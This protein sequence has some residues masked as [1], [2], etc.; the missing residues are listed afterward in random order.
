MTTPTSQLGTAIEDAV[1]VGKEAADE[2]SACLGVAFAEVTQG[3]EELRRF[4]RQRA[5][6]PESRAV[7]H[8]L[9]DTSEQLRTDVDELLARQRDNLE[10]FNI[11]FFGRTGA[12]KSSLME[13]LAGGTGEA[14]S[15]AG[16]S[17]WTVEVRKVKWMS[18]VLHDIPGINGW[19]R[20]R[21]R[22]ELEATARAAVEVADLVVLAF[23]NQS[24]QAQEFAKVAAWVRAYGKPVVA[25][26][27]CRN[28]LWRLPPR[29]PAGRSRRQ[30]SKAVQQH[31]TNITA[32]L[33][34]IGLDAVPVVALQTKRAV[35]ARARDYCGPD[36][37]TL[38]EHR[39]L[40]G[41]DNLERWS[42]LPA[43]EQ[44][45]A[46]ALEHDAPA[47]R[48][49]MLNGQ[50]RGALDAAMADWQATHD[51]AVGV[52][53]D[54][55]RT[56]QTMLDIVGRVAEPSDE[57]AR[58]RV[59]KALGVAAGTNA[60]RGEKRL[61]ELEAL[62]GGAFLV[63]RE[64]DVSRLMRHRLKAELGPLREESLNRAMG[65]LDRALQR[66]QLL[67]SDELQAVAIDEPA[68]DAATAGIVEEI[69]AYLSERVGRAVADVQDDLRARA[70]FAQD[71]DGAAGQGDRT[72]GRALGV[73]A[74]G[75]SA[76]AALG[77]LAIANSWNPLGWA[78]GTAVIVTLVGSAVSAAFGW[79][80]GKKRQQAETKRQQARSRA[81]AY[82]RKQ[83]NNTFDDLEEKIAKVCGELTAEAARGAL[84]Q[85]VEMAIALRRVGKAA[86]AAVATFSGLRDTL[87]AETAAADAIR[88]A[89]ERVQRRSHSK[90]PN[91]LWLGEDWITDAGEVVEIAPLGIQ[92]DPTVQDRFDA[93]WQRISRPAPPNSGKRWLIAAEDALAADTDARAVLHAARSL[94]DLDRA[95][96]AVCGDYSAGKTS[97]LRRLLAEDYRPIPDSLRTGGAA[98][99]AR[100]DSHG[101]LG[102]TLVDTPGLQSGNDLHDR[103]AER[104]TLS[105]GALIY[106]FNPNLVVGSAAFLQL[107][108]VGDPEGLR[109]SKA[110]STIFV[111][112]RADELGVDP[113]DDPDGYRRLCENKRA[114]LARALA[115]RGV[116]VSVDDVFCLAANPYGLV[117]DDA[118][119]VSPETY[120]RT[121]AWDGVAE[122][123]AGFRRS[124]AEFAEGGIDAGVLE[125]GA[126]GLRLLVQDLRGHREALDAQ[127]RQMD[128]LR[129][130]LR[131]AA[132]NGKAIEAEARVR[133]HRILGD[134][135]D[136]LWAE[137]LEASGARRT[138][139]VKRLERWWEDDSLQAEVEEWAA[140]FGRDVTQWAITS[141][142]ALERRLNAPA[143]RS[144]FPDLEAANLGFL[145]PRGGAEVRAVAGGAG[146]AT[147]A[148]GDKTVVLEVFHRFGHKFKPW[149]AT[150]LAA[151]FAKV[152]VVLGVASATWD[153]W[154]FVRAE[155]ADRQSSQRM[156]AIQDELRAGVRSAVDL[157]VDGDERHPGPCRTIRDAITLI[158]EYADE[159]RARKRALKQED[160]ELDARMTSID[161][162]ALDAWSIL[163]LEGST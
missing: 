91:D 85:P 151:R 150:K 62:R 92:P 80:S 30:L 115:S 32:E 72:F 77:G 90:R 88:A 157:L 60:A 102:V 140:D 112:N 64:S 24:Q 135:V 67:A 3:H 123:I 18:C 20:D 145:R 142:D 81:R 133:L 119:G 39:R 159:T 107:A 154:A 27:N 152:G 50:L 139:L 130:E 73:G 43:L 86:G 78:A 41:V 44:L 148:L 47:I 122:L 109:A 101:W 146:K 93:A 49:G 138:A 46:A 2:L 126:A 45:L 116:E 84:E 120:A 144:A 129:R 79:L 23:D 4:A 136:A 124:R 42:N 98:T 65:A 100:A 38:E 11:A 36:P 147:R 53:E 143:F 37:D 71:V 117:D 156:E 63:P 51:H 83:I 61:A 9:I 29:V 155:L 19:G 6:S 48:L 74:L 105:A 114:E 10:S 160:A 75:G 153:A 58:S 110:R 22:E 104:A 15:P 128:R 76:M 66:R 94:A 59:R 125:L 31:V 162:V 54:L 35:F 118:T 69:A 1:V 127:R 13:A 17:D 52:A 134:H 28:A 137:V 25:V 95:R 99:T 26:L 8:R 57:A 103:E 106:L 149:G 56:I 108:L 113:E 34:K 89:R 33:S 12:G 55:E 87:P 96:I 5:L 111:I 82:V 70:A 40:Y 16:A 97:F 132:R 131:S 163:N 158:E 7:A 21:P 121:R 161:A 68:I 14:I 141:E